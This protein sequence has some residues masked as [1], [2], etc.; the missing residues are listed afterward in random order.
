VCPPN[1][2]SLAKGSRQSG[3]SSTAN[4]SAMLRVCRIILVRSTASRQQCSLD[5]TGALGRLPWPCR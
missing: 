5:H 2:S 4:T 1:R 3:V